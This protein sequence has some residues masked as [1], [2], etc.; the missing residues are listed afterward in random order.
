MFDRHLE[1]GYGISGAN[2]G[3]E[4]VEFGKVAGAAGLVI[5][6]STELLN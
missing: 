1:R 2:P 6:C 4:I 5:L 3:V